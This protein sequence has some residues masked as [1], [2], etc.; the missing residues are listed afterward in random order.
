MQGEDGNDDAPLV[1]ENS[2]Y[3]FAV[4]PLEGEDNLV[5]TK[6]TNRRPLDCSCEVKA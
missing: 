6:Q 2:H 4:E 3:R 5:T 1:F